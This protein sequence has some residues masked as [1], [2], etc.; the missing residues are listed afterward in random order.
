MLRLPLAHQDCGLKDGGS[1]AV[2]LPPRAYSVYPSLVFLRSYVSH[3]GDNIPETW[4]KEERVFICLWMQ[5]CQAIVH[6]YDSGS[7]VKEKMT[8]SR[9][10]G[11]GVICFMEDRKRDM[12]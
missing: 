8:A 4:F 5:K 12:F 7:T 11:E 10:C 2:A 6:S 1:M 3:Y 9:S